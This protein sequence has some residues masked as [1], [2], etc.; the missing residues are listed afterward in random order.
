MFIEQNKSVRQLRRG[1]G[2]DTIASN[3]NDAN[4]G[5]PATGYG[6]V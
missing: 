2:T 6:F 3:N 5:D 1:S 4:K